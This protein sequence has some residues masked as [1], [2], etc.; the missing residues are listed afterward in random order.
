MHFRN[1]QDP[2]KAKLLLEDDAVFQA[3]FLDDVST[4]KPKG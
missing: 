1:V 4:D 3:N 2:R